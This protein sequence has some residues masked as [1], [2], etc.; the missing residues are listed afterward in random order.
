MK[1]IILVAFLVVISLTTVAQDKDQFTKDTE[2]LMEIMIKPS[3]KPVIAQFSA[4]VTDDKK[5]AFTKEVEATMPELY[6]NMAI[7]YMK[8]FS[9][10]EIKELLKFYATPLGKKMAEKSI[11]LAQK[12]AMAG[13]NWG[14]KIQGLLGKYQ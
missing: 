7:I 1:K 2:T 8:E 9:H 11:D 3:F 14:M 13:Q 6:E 5:E 12:G 4:M 10:D